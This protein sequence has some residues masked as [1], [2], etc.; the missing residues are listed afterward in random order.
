MVVTTVHYY[1]ANQVVCLLRR[2]VWL[3]AAVLL[4]GATLQRLQSHMRSSS[5]VLVHAHRPRTCHSTL[6]GGTQWV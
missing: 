4:Q 3:P 2:C 6:L 5:R 1:S